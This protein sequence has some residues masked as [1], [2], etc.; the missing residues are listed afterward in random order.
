MALML[1][2]SESYFFLMSLSSSSAGY[3]ELAI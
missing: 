2:D 1:M 3:T